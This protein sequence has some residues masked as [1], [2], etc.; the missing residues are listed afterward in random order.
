MI[1][2]SSQELPEIL[3]AYSTGF[4]LSAWTYDLSSLPLSPSLGEFLVFAADSDISHTRRSNSVMRRRDY[5][6]TSE[7]HRLS[8]SD[9]MRIIKVLY[10]INFLKLGLEQVF[11]SAYE[12]VL[13]EGSQDV[14][15]L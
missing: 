15:C 4:R 2:I 14:V 6:Q 10:P 12:P 7:Q 1:I 5:S 13:V 9:L 8:S 3:R 11:L